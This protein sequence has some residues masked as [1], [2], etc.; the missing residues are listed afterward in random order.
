MNY[1]N[2]RSNTKHGRS[3]ICLWIISFAWA[4]SG[5]K[6]DDPYVAGNSAG[7]SSTPYSCD[8]TPDQCLNDL[9]GVYEGTFSGDLEGTWRVIVDIEGNLSGT[10]R[11]TSTGDEYSVSGAADDEGDIVFGTVSDGSAFLGRVY[12]DYTVSG[13]W[14]LEGHSGDFEG[15]RVSAGGTEY[16]GD[17]DTDIDTEFEI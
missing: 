10:T 7:G 9:A 11:N 4:V 3:G 13:T 14:S 8:S 15:A 17:T 5:C 16:D 1:R 12:S 2:K 6:T